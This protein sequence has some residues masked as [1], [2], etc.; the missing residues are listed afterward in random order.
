VYSNAIP[1]VVNENDTF[2]DI[3]KKLINS[4]GLPITVKEDI[5]RCINNVSEDRGISYYVINAAGER[6]LVNV[7]SRVVEETEKH[8]TNSIYMVIA[9]QVGT[10]KH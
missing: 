6:N 4:S 2:E 3:E 5:K 9:R 1:I 8:G 7:R 10:T